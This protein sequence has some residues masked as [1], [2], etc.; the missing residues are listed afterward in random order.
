[1]V[2][3]IIDFHKWLVLSSLLTDLV[4]GRQTDTV[5]LLIVLLPFLPYFERDPYENSGSNFVI[6][7][8][9]QY[10][11]VSTFTLP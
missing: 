10:S 5:Q 1:M 6:C 8:V 9:L 2:E 11:M 3:E 4:N 7:H